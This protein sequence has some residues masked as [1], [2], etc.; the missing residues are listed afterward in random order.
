VRLRG[1]RVHSFVST[2]TTVT[3]VNV[4]VNLNVNL[5][6]NLNLLRLQQQHT[7]ICTIMQQHGRASRR[8][9]SFL[10]SRIHPQL[11]LS[12]R[13]SQQLLN[14]LTTS[15]RAHLDREHPIAAPEASVKQR[16]ASKQTANPGHRNAPP[17]HAESS[18]S[19]ATKHID[20]ILTNPLFAVVPQ[21]RR[22]SDAAKTDAKDVLR[23]PLSWFLGQ[24]AIGAA[25]VKTATACLEML[26]RNEQAAGLR[27]SHQ[28]I[29]PRRPAFQIAEWLRTSGLETS[30]EFIDSQSAFLDP[31]VR[32]LYREGE[33]SSIWRWFSRSPEQRIKET[34]LKRS[35]ITEFRVRLLK[36]IV[37]SKLNGTH[38]AGPAINAFLTARH[39]Q[40]SETGT[41]TGKL[42]GRSGFHILGIILS[43]PQS[44][45]SIETYNLFLRSTKYWARR[46]ALVQAILWLHHPSRPDF[47]QG[48]AYLRDPERDSIE[49]AVVSTQMRQLSVHLCLEVARQA[50][51]QEK[52][53]DAM[54]ALEFARK[55][56]PDLVGNT[57][58]LNTEA[59]TTDSRRQQED[60]NLAMLDRLLPI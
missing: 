43:H 40:K 13:E 47:R 7:P 24:I 8:V 2:S 57:T 25:D 35:H 42:F 55:H 4:N 27:P 17:S 38:D 37:E 54:F 58:D 11:P 23:D 29:N 6:L 14:L 19:I 36:A 60:L 9:F 48:I 50:L 1:S 21:P 3:T 59:D 10:A 53:Q 41:V 26:E 56:F 44:D 45:L 34:G 32:S 33:E 30:R 28:G 16:T 51:A 5:N 31:L 46:S 12:Q 20:S 15:F 52:Y 49:D 39:L 18:H 22:G